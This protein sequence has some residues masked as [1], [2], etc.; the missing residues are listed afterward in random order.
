MP[1]QRNLT[2][3]PN[4]VI[5]RAKLPPSLFAIAIAQASLLMVGSIFSVPA[6]A[7]TGTTG[8]PPPGFQL[9]PAPTPTATPQ[10]Q[11]PVDIEG[12]VPITPRVIPT[13]R[14]APTPTQQPL[15]TILQP[16]PRATQAAETRRFTPA[17]RATP[18]QRMPGA[19][20]LS[21]EETPASP[22]DLTPAEPT[23]ENV[24]SPTSLPNITASGEDSAIP[25]AVDN[26]GWMSSRAIWFALAAGLIA[27]LAGIFLLRSRR[28]MAAANVAPIEP[29]VVRKPD[30]Q[31]APPAPAPVSAPTPPP[32]NTPPAP[33]PA[34]AISLSIIPTKLSRSMMNATLSC[35]I[36]VHNHTDHMFENIQISGDLV[37]AHGKISIGEQ[38]ADGSTDLALLETLATL[39]AGK[40]GEVTA[41]LTLPVS[42]IRT[43]AQGR[44]TLYVPLLRLRAAGNGLD[45]VTQTF[46][47]GMKPPGSD[48][49]QPFRLDE[50]PQT[51]RQI[52]SRALD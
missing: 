7:T 16:V 1:I 21:G 39:P 41:T 10:V 30:A 27:L 18:G 48:K 23:F 25:G 37:T 43:I 8:A 26:R 12:P 45:P 35:A 31:P 40:T 38:L 36:T 34:G 50:M 49:V 5:M 2:I 19:D 46:V 9:P 22:I 29:P 4:I 32:E 13:A 51:Y 11:G 6:A 14:P 42:H 15:P 44:A 24:P 52:G 33:K 17:A 28:Q 3:G 47:I 20:L